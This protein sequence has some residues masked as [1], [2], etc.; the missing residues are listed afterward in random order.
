[1]KVAL[2]T[3][4]ATITLAQ[5]I[6]WAIAG[7]AIGLFI[8]GFL[9]PNPP[10][11]VAQ[12]DRQIAALW[13]L[14]GF[15]LVAVIAFIVRPMGLGWWLAMAAQVVNAAMFVLATNLFTTMAVN[16]AGFAVDA[17]AIAAL[18]MMRRTVQPPPQPQGPQGR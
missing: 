13:T 15:N 1:M 5:A 6:V 9:V 3:I 14:A 2:M 10:A 11:V 12:I 17:V 4:V 7:V 16:E 8:Q 18:V